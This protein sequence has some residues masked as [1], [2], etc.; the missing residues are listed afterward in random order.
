MLSDKRMAMLIAHR[1][2][3]CCFCFLDMKEELLPEYL[4][5]PV[6]IADALDDRQHG[7]EDVHRAQ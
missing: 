3:E 1:P 4:E 5:L 7:T 6:R 2:L